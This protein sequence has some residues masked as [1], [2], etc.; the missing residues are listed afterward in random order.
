[1]KAKLAL[2]A[3]LILAILAALAVRQFVQDKE[4]AIYASH[5]PVSILVAARNINEGE[6]VSG[7]SLMIKEYPRSF[8]PPDAI[9]SN[10]RATVTGKKATRNIR[11][12]D[13]IQW[14]DLL[15]KDREKERG[16]QN[17]LAVGERAMTISVT[18]T[19]GVGGMIRPGDRVDIYA[20]FREKDDD[21]PEG[22]RIFTNQ[23]LRSVLVLA[24]GQK[25]NKAEVPGAVRRFANM[26]KEE[27][28]NA[29][30]FSVT[31]LEAGI[32]LH[33]RQT[34]GLLTMT[35]RNREDIVDMERI[36]EVNSDTFWSTVKEAD[37][38][39]QERLNKLRHDDPDDLDSEL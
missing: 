7:P 6:V 21:H 11:G 1:M 5:K 4:R 20:T 14:N 25:I 26:N 9:T 18:K 34:G 22:F 36:P 3:A 10:D 13:P 30:T 17:L 8:L 32:I 31:P 37:N 33:A 39:R 27:S 38:K 23:V 15:D 16:L 19:S 24:T 28:F 35:L 2:L 29:L 12:G